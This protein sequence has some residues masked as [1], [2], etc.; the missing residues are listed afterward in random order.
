LSHDTNVLQF[1]E[2]LLPQ[3]IHSTCSPS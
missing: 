2:H 3:K 1:G